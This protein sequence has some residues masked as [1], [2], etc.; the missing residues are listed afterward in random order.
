MRSSE[1]QEDVTVR[2]TSA[3]LNSD[4]FVRIDGPFQTSDAAFDA[5]SALI[6]ECRLERGLPP[7]S[8]IGDFVI[9]PLEGAATRDFQTLHFD[10]GSRPG[11]APAQANSQSR[12]VESQFPSVTEKSY[13]APSSLKRSWS[14]SSCHRNRMA[15]IASTSSGK[16]I[17]TRLD[18]LVPGASASASGAVVN[19][20]IG[21]PSVR[22][23]SIC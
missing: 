13:V 7:M 20:G 18:A 19:L 8:V 2:G 4:G 16:P 1:T 3:A 15:S 17:E 23:C 6:E 12:T 9:P 14:A 10:F 5:A 11:R 21:H 22:E